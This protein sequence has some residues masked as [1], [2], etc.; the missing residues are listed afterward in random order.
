MRGYL[1]MVGNHIKYDVSR[2]SDAGGSWKMHRH[3]K[4]VRREARALRFDLGLPQCRFQSNHCCPLPAL[5]HAQLLASPPPLALAHCVP[6]HRLLLAGQLHLP[7]T[8]LRTTIACPA[9]HVLDD[10][11][12]LAQLT[13]LLI[14][15]QCRLQPQLNG[16][17]RTLI[18]M[19]ACWAL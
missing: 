10:C 1:K 18:A 15:Q 14:V 19:D 11:L 7:A 4:K 2:R 3:W 16:K 13:R 8:H 12:Q 6:R 17:S 5:C 9:L